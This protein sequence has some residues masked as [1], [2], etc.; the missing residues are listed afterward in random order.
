MPA[1]AQLTSAVS[2]LGMALSLWLG[3]Y[4]VSRSPRSRLAWQAG[5]TLWT[6]A[7][8]FIDSIVSI[9]PSP[10][11]S[12]WLGWPIN[13][14]IAIWYHLSLE[15]LPP[16]RAGRQRP[17]LPMV[18][19]LMILFDI[20]LA[21]TP[22]VVADAP[23]GL[24]VFAKIFAPGPLF[25]FLPVSLIGL[26]SLTLYN[27]WRARQAVTNL[28]LRKQLNSLVRGT[29]FGA[30]AVGYAV[31]IVTLK[32]PAP[33]LPIVFLFGLA[34]ATLGYGTVRYSALIE[35]RILRFDIALNGLLILAVSLVYYA[36]IHFLVRTGGIVVDAFVIALAILTHTVFEFARRVLERPF[37]RRSER[38][39]RAALR[40][41]ALEVG[42]REAIEEGL[43]SALAAVVVGAASRWG[44]IVI[45][46]GDDFVI[47]ASFHSKP[48]GE[49]LPAAGLEVR[50]LTTLA[51]GAAAKPLPELAV[52]APLVADDGSLGAILLGQPKNGVSYS[53]SDL[54]LVAEAA[55]DL[56]DLLRQAQ[57]QEAQAR[58]IEHAL[59]TFREREH[60][61]Q[62][63]IETLRAPAQFEI[64][65]KQ[66]A[67]VEDALKRLHD[68]S[69]L[70]DHPLAAFV[71][72]SGATH[73]DR[74][75]A[76]N[77]ALIAA[78]E[79]LRPAGTEPREL[80]P[81]EWHPYV[82][83]C[84]A[85]IHGQSNREIMARLYVSEATFHRTRRRALRA[86]AKALFEMDSAANLLN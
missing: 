18:Y 50:E 54:D 29:V 75:K 80:P 66:V 32:L 31:A 26:M 47:H 24:A 68:Y 71:T 49:R 4:L 83:L 72:L 10:A 33:T 86:V 8:I 23:G 41:V 39:L 12:W 21:F 84:D 58:E 37:L 85:Y 46:E 34:V 22:W 64:G 65:D 60:Q 11:T 42:E 19:G 81:R 35:G 17:F 76:L 67:E 51:P 69:Y 53:D 57:R 7:G 79:K 45:R 61:L 20:L 52:V 40:T 15:T 44:A 16:D 62:Q 59:D 82:T 55:D 27:F 38:A 30:L 9:N 2:F 5:L 77:A 78:I 74:G 13:L 36:A 48:V 6:L 1:L 28:A 25:I 14:P 70:G 43:R 3:C 63:E 56:T 73:L